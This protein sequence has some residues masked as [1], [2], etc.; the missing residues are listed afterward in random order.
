[1]NNA[2]ETARVI[3]R[4]NALHAEQIATLQSKLAAAEQR[5]SRLVE[6][7]Q[8]ALECLKRHIPDGHGPHPNPEYAI[9]ENLEAALSAED[10]K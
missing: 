6:S 5:A 9:V 1:M 3:A 7:A 2:L 8:E 4:L 10:G